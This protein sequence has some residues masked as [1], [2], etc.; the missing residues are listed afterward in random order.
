MTCWM[1]RKRKVKQIGRCK[2]CMQTKC[3]ECGSELAVFVRT[4]TAVKF[5]KKQWELYLYEHKALV[6]TRTFERLC[7]NPSCP[8]RWDPS[9][10][11]PSWLPVPK[12]KVAPT[13]KS[14][15]EALAQVVKEALSA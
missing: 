15:E 11:P 8:R 4:I 1:C 9:K 3:I 10:L 7:V 13:K 5:R 12:E 6:K 2:T 14:L